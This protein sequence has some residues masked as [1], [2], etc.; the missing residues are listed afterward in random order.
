MFNVV[1]NRSAAIAFARGLL[2][3][4]LFVIIFAPA[5]KADTQS[6]QYTIT[7]TSAPAYGDGL[8]FNMALSFVTSG[9]L[10]SGTTNIDPNS[11]VVLAA[12]LNDSSLVSLT[13]N[14]GEFHASFVGQACP[15]CG[16][17][18]GTFERDDSYSD[19]LQSPITGAG[20]FQPFISEVVD[21]THTTSP[22]SESFQDFLNHGGFGDSVSVVATPEPN[23]VFLVGACFLGCAM[24][25]LLRRSA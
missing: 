14:N 8:T 19:F 18:P 1:E 24:I 13:A 21:T 2:I 5:A 12:P 22:P 15:G 23:S 17:A 10:G 6:F 16:Y 7:F 25:A 3:C 9:L 11:V 4:S 20:T